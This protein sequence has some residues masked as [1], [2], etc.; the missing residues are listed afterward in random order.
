MFASAI[1]DP[2]RSLLSHGGTLVL[3]DVRR[4]LP[5]EEAAPSLA[6]QAEAN[7]TCSLVRNGVLRAMM[8]VH[9]MSPRDWTE[10]EIGLVHEVTERCWSLIEQRAAE[11]K[12]VESQMLVQIASRVAHMGG[13]RLTVPDS[14][15]AFARSR[16]ASRCAHSF[17]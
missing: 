14:R 15:S 4:E 10:A 13:W 6:I 9:Q 11:A 5:P 16:V 2:L 12:L 8:G 17:R 7:V 3:R 1:S